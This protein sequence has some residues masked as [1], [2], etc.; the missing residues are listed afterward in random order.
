MPVSRVHASELLRC[1]QS[2]RQPV[3]LFDEDRRLVFLNDACAELLK[4]D[5]ADVLGQTANYQSTGS[6]PS[7]QIANN[8]CP[9]P[10]AFRGT[11]TTAMI[12]GAL[13]QTD[14][15]YRAEYIPLSTA[16]EQSFSV[17]A[18]VALESQPVET[19]SDSADSTKHFDEAQ[20]LHFL[21]HSLRRELAQAYQLNRLAGKSASMARVRSQIKVAAG[22]GETI[23]IV[24]PKGI[25][26]EHVARTIH[27]MHAQSASAFVPISCS[28]VPAEALRS[29]LK[30]HL[31]RNS[32]VP[33]VE[34]KT[35]ALLDVE[36]LPIEIQAEVAAWL[37][38][39]AGATRVIATSTEL[40]TDWI[41]ANKIRS[42]LANRLSTLVIELPPL[43]QR[44][45]DISI[46][47]QMLLEDLN[48]Q[49][50]KQ[51]RGFAPEAMDRLVQYDWPGQIDELAGI[52]REAFATAEGVEVTI[53]DLPK[54]LQ[55]AAEAAR[56]V[57]KPPQRIDLEQ[58]LAQIETELIERALRVAK[59]NKSEAARL[60]GLN[61][62]KLYRRM[63]QLGLADA[64]ESPADD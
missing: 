21:I 20:Q 32:N 9:P 39:D 12:P 29:T 57:R 14:M 56:F 8:L 46:I 54:R 5:A 16:D 55:Q 6:T 26:R 43:S 37:E 59:Q 62:P 7:S 27:A 50:G 40:P 30:S 3:Y 1:L 60:L 31:R 42:D 18:V 34:S 23:L 53:S 51:L 47:A 33:G 22:C 64:D 15:S 38:S 24:G 45:E 63:V 36:Q 19:L 49:G 44:P 28:A 41:A 11:R 48:G 61:R 13:S 25:G 58:F 2:V 10:E 17:L 52:V 35:L 4:I